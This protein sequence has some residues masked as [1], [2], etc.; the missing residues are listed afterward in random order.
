MTG[1]PK[2][3]RRRWVWPVVAALGLSAVMQVGIVVMPDSWYTALHGI[4]GPA[5]P[6]QFVVDEN[7]AVWAVDRV[8]LGPFGEAISAQSDMERFFRDEL[9]SQHSPSPRPLVVPTWSTFAR[10]SGNEAMLALRASA[11]AG[12]DNC[13]ITEMAEGW[14]WRCVRGESRSVMTWA[15]RQRTIARSGQALLWGRT[16]V[17][18]VPIWPGLVLNLVVL[19][20]PWY[21]AYWLHGPGRR[22]YRQ[23]R[24]C[25]TAC[26]YDLAGLDR[27]TACPECG[28]VPRGGEPAAAGG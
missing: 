13:A 28:A 17:P 22:V 4:P 5:E 7:D 27:C 11:A 2:R 6:R 10:A 1:T 9:A 25:C 14:P 24:G 12:W 3:T 8:D 15:T 20:L 16:W 19:A 18:S 23:Y 26:G 21:A